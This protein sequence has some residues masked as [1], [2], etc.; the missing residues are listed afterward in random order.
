MEYCSNTVY[1]IVCI[2]NHIS[3]HI[4]NTFSIRL[5]LYFSLILFVC[6]YMSVP[7]SSKKRP[8]ASPCALRSPRAWPPPLLAAASL[9]LA[10]S[11]SLG[12]SSP[13]CRRHALIDAYAYF[14]LFSLVLPGK[15]HTYYVA[16]TVKRLLGAC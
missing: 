4:S 7:K 6:L 16:Y 2:I 1:A 10:S 11:G 12:P 3:D 13:Q 15:W 14:H 5:V 9:S 8:L